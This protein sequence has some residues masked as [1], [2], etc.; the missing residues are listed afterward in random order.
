[1]RKILNA[2]EHF[3]DDFLAG[4]LRAHPEHFA[5]ISGDPRALVDVGARARRQQAGRVGIVT[6]GGSSHLPLSR[7][8]VGEGLCSAVAVGNTFSSPSAETILAATRE[9]DS[10]QGVLSL[11]G[12][13]SG[14]NLNFDD[15]SR[16]ARDPNDD[17]ANERRRRLGPASA[18]RR[19]R[20]VAGLVIAYKSAG[21]AAAAGTALE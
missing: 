21:A 5:A 2:P 13:Y 16:S 17:R 15:A 9:S 3:V 4:P 6:G 10:G 7:G 1:M 14:D 8:Y 19:R 12:N 11:Y 20:G 18:A